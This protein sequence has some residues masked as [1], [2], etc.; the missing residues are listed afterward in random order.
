MD[1][2]QIVF[3]ELDKPKKFNLCEYFQRPNES[4]DFGDHWNSVNSSSSPVLRIQRI[5]LSPFTKDFRVWGTYTG[6]CPNFLRLCLAK[7]IKI[8][9]DN[10]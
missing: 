10:D 2:G 9:I 6:L 3:Q 1:N 4:L 7:S 8:Y 5:N